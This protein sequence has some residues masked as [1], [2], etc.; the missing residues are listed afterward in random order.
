MKD[1]F[2]LNGVRALRISL[3]LI[4]K[5]EGKADVNYLNA[6]SVRTMEKDC[7]QDTGDQGRSIKL[8]AF[9]YGSYGNESRNGGSGHSIVPLTSRHSKRSVTIKS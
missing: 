9:L 2:F 5:G 3:F 8:L 4:C 6:S 7:H 1:F